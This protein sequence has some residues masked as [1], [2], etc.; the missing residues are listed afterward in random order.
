MVSSIGSMLAPAAHSAQMSM[1]QGRPAPLQSSTSSLGCLT[2]FSA[3]RRSQ[4]LRASRIRTVVTSA[5]YKVQCLSY[6]RL[7][8]ESIARPH[9]LHA[10]MHATVWQGHSCCPR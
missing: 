2:P 3:Q 6:L 8:Y 9:P 1:T 4:Q 7:A 5:G 10:G